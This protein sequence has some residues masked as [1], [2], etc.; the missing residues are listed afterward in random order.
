MARRP[1]SDPLGRTIE[2]AL[3]PGWSISWPETADFVA[4]LEESA[5]SIE[6]LVAADP[7][8]AVL[9]YEAF[10]AGCF[11]KAE[12][13]DD[14]GG[15]FGSFVEGMFLAWIRA[16]QAA[17]AMPRE[18]VAALFAWIEND[19]YGYCSGLASKAAQSLDRKGRAAW[20][21]ELRRR[22]E[23]AGGGKSDDAS[24]ARRR[25][26]AALKSLYVETRNATAYA[27]VCEQTELT[28]DDCEAIARSLAIRRKPGE[29][30]QWVQRGLELRR[31]AGRSSTGRCH[32]PEMKRALLCKLGRGG[33]ALESAWEQYREDPNRFAYEDLMR[34]VPRGDR[35]SWHEQ[36]MDV[37]TRG[38]LAMVIDLLLYT[39]EIDRLAAR[40][41]ATADEVLEKLSHY[42]TEP[43]AKR[44]ARSA[45]EVAAKLYRALAVRILD[46]AKSKYYDA[47]LSHL[48]E[49]R[50]CYEKAGRR[51]EWTA[52]SAQLRERHRRKA[53]IVDGLTNIEAGERRRRKEPSLLERARQRWPYRGE[54]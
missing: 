24:Y 49:A 33:E 32:L 38:D 44:L 45:P 2:L 36:A 53:R 27:A 54:I 3:H 17:G 30:L 7:S 5:K 37:T 47:A 12:E 34:Y 11:E 20:E 26:G 29:A 6:K 4:G 48:R 51:D 25:W 13:I 46:A 52:L 15:D 43:A 22:F 42:A 19:D 8:R 41:R 16:R 28:A 40:L 23:A 31:E 18:T 1:R 21:T 10:I 14:S 9:L 35:P 39:R 50:L